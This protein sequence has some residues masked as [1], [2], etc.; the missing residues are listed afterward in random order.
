MKALFFTVMTGFG[1]SLVCRIFTCYAVGVSSQNSCE[2]CHVCHE[3]GFCG[4]QGLVVD[5]HRRDCVRE[6]LQ[7]DLFHSGGCGKI[8]EVIFKVVLVDEVVD[9]GALWVHSLE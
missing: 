8:V 1:A 4:N 5:C 7:N 2:V 3:L 9:C 6:L